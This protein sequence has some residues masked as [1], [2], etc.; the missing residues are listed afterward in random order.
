MKILTF[1]LATAQLRDPNTESTMNAQPDILESLGSLEIVPAVRAVE[2]RRRQ[3]V[4][5]AVQ[6]RVRGAVGTLETFEEI[7]KSLDV[8][9]DGVLLATTR[10]GYAVGEQLQVT[11]PYWDAPTA[12]NIPRKAKVIR[13]VILPNFEFALALQ[14]LPGIC[15]EEELAGACSPFANQVR[16]LGVQSDPQIADRLRE[17]LEQDGYNVVIAAKAQQALEILQNET[18]NVI[19]AEAEGGDICGNDLCAIVKTC[20]RLRHIPVILLTRSAL[21]SDYATSRELGAVMCM[22]MPCKLDRLRRAVHLVAP[23]P[24]LCS[25]YSSRFNLSSFVRTC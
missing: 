21:P 1:S 9:R 4:K 3:R 19:L 8:S 20:A 2:R 15:A 12:I 5:L 24:A 17:M 23:P 25:V 7:V 6:A 10:G 11:C 18:P 14:F 22:T 13:N 16:V